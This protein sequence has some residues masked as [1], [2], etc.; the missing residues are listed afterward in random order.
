M[1]TVT[2]SAKEKL[3]ELMNDS[4]KF[5]RVGVKGGGCSGLSYILEFDD[6]N[7]NDEVFE[8]NGVIVICD[9]KS[10]LYIFGTINSDLF[11][12]VKHFRKFK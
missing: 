12:Y 4:S 7:E 11:I 2:N 6:I 10:L 1:I 5:L 3:M 9:K 8:D